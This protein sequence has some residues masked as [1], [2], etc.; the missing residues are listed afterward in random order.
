M[1]VTLRQ[2]TVRRGKYTE[3]YEADLPL[4]PNPKFVHPDVPFNPHARPAAFPTIPL[5]RRFVERSPEPTRVQRLLHEIDPDES[6]P[7]SDEELLHPEWT[8][9]GFNKDLRL[10]W[11]TCRTVDFTHDISDGM[12]LFLGKVVFYCDELLTMSKNV[13]HI[14]FPN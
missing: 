11:T 13:I 5:D 6:G 10:S 4:P 9:D 3:D 8:S 14:R 2:R 1:P 7:P 12:K